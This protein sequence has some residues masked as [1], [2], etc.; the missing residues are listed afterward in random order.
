MSRPFAFFGGATL[1]RM[2]DGDQ[3]GGIASETDWLAAIDFDP[4]SSWLSMGTRSL[5]DRPWLITD[6]NRERELGLRAELIQQRRAEVICG[7]ASSGAAVAE[8]L[9]LVEQAG[10]VVEPA[11]ASDGGPEDLLARLG[12]SVTEDLCV[13]R[14]GS[15]EWEFEAAV[16]CFPS[17]W[18]LADRIGRPLREVHAPTTG[19][20]P[21]LADRITSMLDRIGGQIVRRRNWFIH[22]D[23]ALFQPDRLDVEPVVRGEAV[24]TELF[25]RSERQ[26]LRA[27]PVSGRMLFTIKTQQCSIGEVVADDERRQR[28]L[29]YVAEAPDDQIQHRGA[30]H[31]QRAALLDALS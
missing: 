13:L 17:R 19:Y 25:L 11:S 29:A 15:V 3:V 16:L 22:P 12:R 2:A 27:L 23:P 5:G 24:R 20:D 4:R 1:D 6:A 14:R 31:E 18:R 28:F 7:P 21:V 30:G 26:T 10:G 9:V 8:T